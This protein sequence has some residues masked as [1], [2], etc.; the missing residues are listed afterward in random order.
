VKGFAGTRTTA[1]A[2]IVLGIAPLRATVVMRE[3]SV[4]FDSGST[5]LSSKAAQILDGFIAEWNF[6]KGGRVGIAANADRTGSPSFN[7]R[8]SCKRAAAVAAYLGVRG[9]P[10]DRMTLEGWGEE[11]PLVETA[12]GIAEWQNRRVDLILGPPDDWLGADVR[13]D[14]PG[15]SSASCP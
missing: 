10:K 2:A 4:F 14:S 9:I 3:R 15:P 1:G 11:R 5:S 8:L 7:R 12:D 6:A 13:N